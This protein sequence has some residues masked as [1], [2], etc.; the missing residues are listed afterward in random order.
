MEKAITIQ[1]PNY[2]VAESDPTYATRVLQTFSSANEGFE[3]DA[4]ALIET[5]KEAGIEYV[6][7]KGIKREIG[8]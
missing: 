3:D 1:Y 7:S 2:L 4:N 6:V 5:L 8:D